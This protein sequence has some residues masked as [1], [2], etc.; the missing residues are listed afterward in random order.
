MKLWL[1]RWT[2]HTAIPLYALIPRK[3]AIFRMGIKRVP[4]ARDCT[5]EREAVCGD[6]NSQRYDRSISY[7]QYDVI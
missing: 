4:G 3:S 6:L 5:K 7:G 2:D 1:G